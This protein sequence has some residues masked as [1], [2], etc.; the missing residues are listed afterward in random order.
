MRN[1][2]SK[3]DAQPE[4]GSFRNRQARA[5]DKID[6]PGDTYQ[7]HPGERIRGP[8]PAKKSKKSVYRF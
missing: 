6:L 4:K 1:A 7:D 8:G 3:C 2:V 5:K